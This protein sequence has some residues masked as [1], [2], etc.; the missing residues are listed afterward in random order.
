VFPHPGAWAQR[1]NVNA[2]VAVAVP[3]SLPDEVAAQMLANPITVLMLRRAAQAHFS[4]G[5]DGVILNNAA[6]SS[7]GRL[8]TAV[9]E[10]HQI[11][12][13]SIVRS[14]DRAEQLRQRFPSV[15]VVSTSTPGWTDQVRDVSGGRAIPVALDPIGGTVA[16]DLISLLSPGG[17]L[18]SYGLMASENIP[19]HASA[20]LGSSLGLR[21]L[22]IRRWLSSV[23]PEQRASD[24]AGAL[25]I[26]RG[27]PQHFDAAANI[28]SRRSVTPPR[29]RPRRRRSLTPSPNPC[30]IDH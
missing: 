5:F 22:T 8:F 18:I 6:A 13:I 23:S 4:V 19:L 12:T 14:E 24:V 10:H 20:L 27:V 30:H 25:A 3:D 17:T 7:V 29:R 21:G 2:D 26:A 1:I 15:P 28:R 9:A 11:A 16:A